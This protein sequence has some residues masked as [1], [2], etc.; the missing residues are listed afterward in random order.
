M[1][2][3]KTVTHLTCALNNVSEIFMNYLT[4]KHYFYCCRIT[5]SVEYISGKIDQI[6]FDCPSSHKQLE[7]ECG[8][9]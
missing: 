9:K 1:H 8:L 7:V 5:Y 3:M 2:S 6:Y 4:I